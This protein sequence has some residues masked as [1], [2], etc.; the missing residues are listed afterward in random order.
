MKKFIIPAMILV[1]LCCITTESQAEVI[2][3]KRDLDVDS[4]GNISSSPYGTTAVTKWVKIP[5]DRAFRVF[6]E[7]GYADSCA[8]FN[9]ADTMHFFVQ[10]APENSYLV[11]NAGIAHDLGHNPLNMSRITIGGLAGG[12]T[13]TP[14]TSPYLPRY[15]SFHPINGLADSVGANAN[16]SMGFVR[17]AICGP[18][19]D[20][21]LDGSLKLDVYFIYDDEE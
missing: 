3:V 21:T 20:S 12:Y 15:L 9:D 4:L 7:N 16:K 2:T 5:P 13:A 17:A 10:T 19:N 6:V 14:S 8:A 1:V 18:D 11:T